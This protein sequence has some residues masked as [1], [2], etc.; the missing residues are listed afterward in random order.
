MGKV[1]NKA[2]KVLYIVGGAFFCFTMLL[3][4]FNVIGRS[5]FDTP[6]PGA[7]ELTGWGAAFFAAVAIPIA[8]MS[9]THVRVVIVVSKIKG[10]PRLALE[11]FAT[12]C[13]VVFSAILT[14]GG[15]QYAIQML[16]QG[17]VTNSV[18]MP[19]GPAR[20]A[21]AISAAIMVIA[22]IYKLTQHPSRT[23]KADDGKEGTV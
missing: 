19:I 6:I 5:F 22:N 23:Q 4:V 20:L 7:Y 13:D 10:A 2:Q 1:I 15:F 17:E 18:N 12:V 3:M 11:I 14:Y 8:T 21:W 9:G 16:A